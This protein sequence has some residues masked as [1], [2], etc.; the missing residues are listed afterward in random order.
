M[1]KEVKRVTKVTKKPYVE[2]KDKI[3]KLIEK[4][5]I[6]GKEYENLVHTAALSCLVHA[7]K[8]CDVTLADTLLKSI[9][10]MAR[11]NVLIEWF[12]KFGKF[13]YNTETKKFGY[14]KRKES[15]IDQAT[16]VPFW[17]FKAEPEYKGVNFD[18]LI[19]SAVNQA[20]LGMD[21]AVDLDEDDVDDKATLKKIKVDTEFFEKVKTLWIAREAKLA[22]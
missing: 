7:D 1:T 6:T 22:A 3:T 14:A 18:S 4:V 15:D 11:K 13:A 21:L 16:K 19:K 10:G 2:G 17:V 5:K 12:E 20:T 9:S 8:T